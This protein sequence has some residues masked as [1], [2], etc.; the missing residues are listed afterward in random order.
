[1]FLYPTGSLA[2]NNN[3]WVPN[4][5]FVNQIQHGLTRNYLYENKLKRN[6]SL[7]MVSTCKG[8]GEC[9]CENHGYTEVQCLEKGCCKFEHNVGKVPSQ[10]IVY[11][12]H[13]AENQN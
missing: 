12:F 4:V 10:R 1:M 7:I 3:L 2:A 11:N 13:S 6:L 5:F 8:N 9:V